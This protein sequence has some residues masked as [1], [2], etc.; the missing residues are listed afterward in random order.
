MTTRVRQAA[1]HPPVFVPPETTL[2]EAAVHMDRAGQRALLVRDGER[3]GIF[4]GVDL[5]RAAVAQRQPLETAGA[6]PRPLRR[7]RR[8]TRTASCSRRPC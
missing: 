5:T 1:V 8:S 3:I 4:T 7:G 2:H 6:R